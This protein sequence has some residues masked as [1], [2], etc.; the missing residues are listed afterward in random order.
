MNCCEKSQ[1]RIRRI[2]MRRE[3][4]EACKTYLVFAI[5]SVTTADTAS[6]TGRSIVAPT[7]TLLPVGT[8]PRHM[9]G[10]STETADDIGREV[11]LLGAVVL[12]MS[13]LT[14]VLTRLVFVV[15]KWIALE[16]VLTLGDGCSLKTN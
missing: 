1:T 15:T 13:D 7:G 4:S 6:V 11:L 9:A 16:F 3:K 5:N 2:G 10:V 12:A 14:T 8:I